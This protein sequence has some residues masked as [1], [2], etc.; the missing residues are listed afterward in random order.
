MWRRSRWGWC[1][2]GSPLRLLLLLLPSCKPD[3]VNTIASNAYHM[4]NKRRVTNLHWGLCRGLLSGLLNTT[5]G[6]FEAPA[7]G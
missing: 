1:V 7:G 5:S 2:G 6:V 3:K 4:S